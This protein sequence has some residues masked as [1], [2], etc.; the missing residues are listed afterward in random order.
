M[1]AHASAVCG[2]FPTATTKPSSSTRDRKTHRAQNIYSLALCREHS[3]IPGIDPFGLPK[4]EMPHEVGSE[5]EAANFQKIIIVI[6]TLAVF[7]II[8]EN[9]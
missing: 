6:I 9:I 1:P 2:G 4:P 5:K 7:K 8:L 3:L